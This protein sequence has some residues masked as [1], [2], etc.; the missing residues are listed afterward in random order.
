MNLA[1]VQFEL[2]EAAEHLQD[3]VAELNEGTMGER[4]EPALA[5]TLAHIL[6]H[7][8][9]AWN[10]KGLTIEQFTELSQEDFE[11]LSHTVPNFFGD[12]AIGEFAAC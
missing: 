9:R 7:L 3:L 4:G 8:C 2:R 12:R 10:C 11:H 5:V 1:V 6:D